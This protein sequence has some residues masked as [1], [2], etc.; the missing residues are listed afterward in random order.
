MLIA[1]QR[2]GDEHRVGGVGVERPVGFVGD[3]DPAQHLPEASVS[4]A[5]SVTRRSRPKRMSVPDMG[6]SG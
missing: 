2:V 6:R 5:A 4:G 3:L 1:G